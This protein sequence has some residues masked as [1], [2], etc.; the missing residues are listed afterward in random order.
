MI[1]EATTN[2]NT[3]HILLMIDIADG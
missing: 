1:H 3:Q 2:I